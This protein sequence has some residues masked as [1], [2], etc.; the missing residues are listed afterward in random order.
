[1]NDIAKSNFKKSERANVS[2][3]GAYALLSLGHHSTPPV[4]ANLNKKINIYKTILILVY[5]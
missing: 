5:G 4:V 2:T 3:L 1:M